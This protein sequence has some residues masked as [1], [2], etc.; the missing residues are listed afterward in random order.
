[1]RGRDMRRLGSAMAMLWLAGGC[2]S[3]LGVDDVSEATATPAPAPTC[4][5]QPDI[6]QV[7]SDADTTLTL[8]SD[9]Y[10]NA[11]QLL[12]QAQGGIA[13]LIGLYDNI[14]GAR[15]VNKP[16]PYTL[17]DAD[18]RTENCGI[19]ISMTTSFFGDADVIEQKYFALPG[20]TMTLTKADATGLAGE[21]DKLQ[22]RHVD[23]QSLQDK[24]TVDVND[25]CNVTIDK[26][27]FSAQYP[28]PG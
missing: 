24:T 22:L 11:P 15:V 10:P 26:V 23:F 12:L 20:A 17:L 28:P 3:L 5:V 7:T 14:G 9:G 19:C 21:I 25:D 18:S 13:L 2:N 4:F 27:T 1:M 6:A 16:G 8:G